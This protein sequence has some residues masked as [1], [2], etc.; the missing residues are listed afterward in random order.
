MFHS[1]LV[2]S[3]S[4]FEPGLGARPNSNG[5]FLNA[6]SPTD[7]AVLTAPIPVAIA[8][9]VARELNVRAVQIRLTRLQ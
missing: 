5:C 2:F 7:L 3:D 1:Y 8:E 4:R 9:L 6:R